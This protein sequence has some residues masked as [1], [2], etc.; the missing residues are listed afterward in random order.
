M[1]GNPIES[2]TIAQMKEELRMLYGVRDV[3]DV[4]E[5]KDLQAKLLSTRNTQLITHGLRYGPLMQ[6]GNQKNPT[7]VVTLSHGLGDSAQGWESV[8]REL[9]GFLPHLLFLL[10]T[11]PVRPVTING[12]MS[13]NAWYDIKD[14]GAALEKSRQDGE[15]VMI[16][17][18]YLKSL[19]YTATQRYRIP[20]NRVVYA[21]F[22]Q[23]A[24]ISLAAGITS[25]I[26][27]A[28][29]AVLSGYLAGGSA[30]MNRLCNKGV[31]IL[32][33]HGLQ[34]DVVPFEAA[35]MTKKELES[36]GVRSITLKSYLM[37]HSAHPD[38]IQDLASFLKR[39]L[40]ATT[41]G[42]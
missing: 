22:S 39:V 24:A 12:G 40:P 7:G 25:R 20:S 11:A 35:R 16:S 27:P 38:E 42:E 5:L 9:A 36:V 14:L 13:M 17:A 33:C 15:T 10:P 28:G 18:D 1:I 6:V 41:S 29:V 21:G 34:D 26:A 3:S 19:A 32:M 23:G 8:A 37:A 4:V 31:P 2:L 30:V